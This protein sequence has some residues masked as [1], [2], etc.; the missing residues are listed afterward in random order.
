MTLDRERLRSTF[1]MAADHY[2]EARPENTQ[3]LYD[4]LIA[5]A[6]FSDGDRL[7]EVGC[8]TAKRP[9]LWRDVDFT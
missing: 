7:L 6:E 2:Q 5:A 3:Q 4:V 9:F 8:A 1:D